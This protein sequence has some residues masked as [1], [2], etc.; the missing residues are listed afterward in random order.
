[1]ST[2]IKNA[3]LELARV[4]VLDGMDDYLAEEVDKL[5]TQ[6]ALIAVGSAWIPLPGADIVAMTANVWTM[7][8]RINKKYYIE[9][10]DNVMKSVGSAVLS[11][12]SANVLALGMGS[13]LKFIPGS[14][15]VTGALMSGVV[16][17]TTLTAAWVYIRALTKFMEQGGG[18]ENVLRMCVDDV[19]DD[20]DSIKSVFKDAKSNYKK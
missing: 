2:F 10:A 3:A 12:L 17:A 20:V 18:N 7:Y 5:V 8:V 9:F 14:S 1:M 16:Y 11:N 15:L 13:L 4:K 6:H 19:L